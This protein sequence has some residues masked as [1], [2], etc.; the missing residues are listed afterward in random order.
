MLV[1]SSAVLRKAF[2]KSPPLILSKALAGKVVSDEQ[3]YHAK[4]KSV[5]LE[6]SING[7]LVSDEHLY[8][9]ARKSVP[10]EVSINGKLVSDE[11]S[12]HA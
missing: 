11:Q 8:H 5:P 7:K 6:V 4:P 10:L 9:A 12:R 2:V 3:L 1:W